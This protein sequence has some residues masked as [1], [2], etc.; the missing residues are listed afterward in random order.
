[1]KYAIVVSAIILALFSRAFLVSV[2]KVPS[3]TMA[4]TIISGDFVFAL[5]TSYGIKFPWSQE[6][7]FA[8]RPQ[9]GDLVAFLKDSKIFIKRVVAIEQDKLEYAG[10][11]FTINSEKCVY[12]PPQALETAELSLVE[13][14]CA[15][16]SNKV[17]RPSD[18]SKSPQ[19]QKLK[20]ENSQIFVASDNRSSENNP[21]MAETIAL[22]QII[23][24]PVLVWMS[25]SSTQDF[26][27]KSLGVRWNRIL[28][29]LQ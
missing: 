19:T 15:D 7:Y 1:M 23:G 24:K 12:G 29:K 4:P 27:S 11:E 5:Q 16:F 17:I 9:R 21:N 2:Y 18:L 8:S 25:Y 14:K 26:I 6:V 13:E 3:H 22:D 20:L 28:T 10:G